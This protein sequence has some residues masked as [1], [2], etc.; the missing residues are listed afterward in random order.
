MSF[1]RPMLCKTYEWDG[2]RPLPAGYEAERKY[3]GH[4]IQIARG[5]FGDVFSRSIDEVVPR[6]DSERLVAAVQSKLG[7]PKTPVQ[8]PPIICYSRL[9][10]VE[11]FPDWLKHLDI[12]RQ[13]IFDGELIPRYP[14]RDGE[15]A[16]VVAH[17][18]TAAPDR[19]KLVLFDVMIYSGRTVMTLPYW[20][21]RDM[22]LR[23]VA[24]LTDTGGWAPN[25]ITEA[26]SNSIY[27]MTAEDFAEQVIADG[28]EGV[29][30]KK[31][32]SEYRPGYR[33]NDWYKIKSTFTVDVIITDADA[34][35]SIWRVRP[36]HRDPR[37]GKVSTLGEL[38]STHNNVGLSYGFMKDGKLLT[39]GSLGL[40]GAPEEMQQYVGRIAEVKA[41]GQYKATG[42]LRHPVFLRWRDDKSPED[43]TVVQ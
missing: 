17:L 41:Y 7:Y 39:V 28:G 22:V 38:S 9:G 4:R 35:P 3:D 29:V 42:A 25:Q 15:G 18:R 37:T 40:T 33:G 21:R 26:D 34:P 23:I 27:S 12:P 13:T 11:K 24:D 1:I 20:K 8:D 43:C 30:L 2:V 14:E 31:R 10:N 36:G 6:E 19:L 32:S 16:Q 5:I